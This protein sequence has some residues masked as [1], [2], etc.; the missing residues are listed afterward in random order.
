VW[1]IAF[2]PDGEMIVSSSED[3]TVKLWDT[4]TGQCIRTLKGYT[5]AFRLIAFSPDGKT[6]VSGSGDR[7]G[8]L[9]NVE[10][11]VC[12]KT[13]PGHTS[14]VVSVAFSPNGKTLASGSTSV[15]LWDSSTGK[16]L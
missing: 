11:G 8:R 7:H 3:H 9:W 2:N 13:L 5:N 4:V 10:A 15:K 14:L 6:W 16:C 12:L 1:S